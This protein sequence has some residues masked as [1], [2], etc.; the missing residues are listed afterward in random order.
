MEPLAGPPSKKLTS[1][2]AAAVAAEGNVLLIAGAGTGKTSTLV[3]RVLERVL[4]PTRRVSLDRI[5]MVTFTE[6]AAAEMRHRLRGELERRQLD[7]GGDPWIAEQIVRIDH[8]PI[9]TIHGFCLR[10]LRDHFHELGLDPQMRVL[11]DVESRSVFEQVLDEVLDPLLAQ[12]PEEKADERSGVADWIS[13]FHGGNLTL[14]KSLVKRVYDYGRSRHD[15]DT[16][17]HCQ[18]E[19]WSAT[20][21]QGWVAEMPEELNR[22]GQQWLEALIAVPKENPK[23][24]RCH[25]LLQELM[26]Q[27]PR[28][29]WLHNVG[30][31]LTLLAE[32]DSESAWEAYPRRKATLRAPLIKLFDDVRFLKSLLVATPNPSGAAGTSSRTV[33]LYPFMEDWTTTRGSMGS[34]LDVVQRVVVALTRTKREQSTV[35][36]ADLEQFALRLLGDGNTPVAQACQKRFEYVLVDEAQD[37]N[38]AQNSILSSV[39]RTGTAANRFLVGDIKQSIYRF[40]L[41]DPRI[42]QAFAHAWSVGNSSAETADKQ[43]RSGRVLPLT[44]NFRSHEAIL[45]FVNSVFT[46]LFHESL[47]GV[48]YDQAAALHFG[49]PEKRRPMSLDGTPRVEVHLRLES[50]ATEEDEDAG[51]T[52]SPEDRT[53][54]EAGLVIARLLELYETKTLVWDG[55]AGA[56]RPMRW[57]DVVVLLR[58]PGPRGSAYARKFADAGIPMDAPPGSLLDQPELLDFLSLLEILDNP[59]QDIPLAT[60][61]R[62]P[63]AGIH[64]LNELAVI[65]MSARREPFWTALNRFY[66]FGVSR[67]RE[68]SPESCSQALPELSADATG[69][70]EEPVDG[71][72]DESFENASG[73][74]DGPGALDHPTTHPW[75]RRLWPR[76]EGFLKLY[77]QWRRL[78]QRGS[79]ASLIET[80]LDDTGYEASIELLE[81]SRQRLANLRSLL[82][83]ARRFDQSQRGGVQRFLS[84]LK[85]HREVETE[86]PSAVSNNAVRLMS[87]H[88]SK[89]L[90]FPITVVAGLG[91][92][93]NQSDLNADVMLDDQGRLCPVVCR[94]GGLRY[95]SWPLWR[96]ARIQL[97]QLLGEELRLLYVAF[98]R[99]SDRLILVGV[100]SEK[101]AANWSQ[102]PSPLP[103]S[104]LERAR[105]PLDWLGPV[106]CGLAG[107]SFGNVGELSSNSKLA[108]R[109]WPARLPTTSTGVPVPVRTSNVDVN[110]HAGVP[111]WRYPHEAATIE[112]AK[113]SVTALRRRADDS[114]EESATRFVGV[115]HRFR[116]LQEDDGSSRL[117][118]NA[119][120][121]GTFH[122]RFLEHVD[123]LKTNSREALEEELERLRGLHR[124]TEE[125]AQALDMAALEQFWLSPLG[126]DLRTHA[127]GVRRE[128]PF[129]LRL[130]LD[131]MIRLQLPHLL[132]LASEEFVVVQGVIDIA[133]F[134]PDGTLWIGDF[135]TD[136]ITPDTLS[137]KAKV[138][139]PQLALYALAMERIFRVRVSRCWLYFL[140]MGLAIDVPVA[141]GTES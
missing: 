95:R 109:I 100:S 11:D 129:T 32:E 35:D 42:F 12:P 92:R 55:N 94:P 20:E 18:I 140:N 141:V 65:R 78:A 6:A 49:A 124:F 127:S 135:K 85:A 101:A 138:Y 90:E 116:I 75:A 103:L 57:G 58:S 114:E 115:D 10:L 15:F 136:R 44:A 9:G 5:L 113:Q 123:L 133:V 60:V 34:V 41:A 40:R 27:L 97:R 125:E 36:F 61:L 52:D 131:D 62:S 120:E 66:E 13:T 108:W 43:I 30:I 1:E 14:A 121:R 50:T 107:S 23:A 98:T 67:F 117:E 74:L 54:V 38:P 73:V 128:I 48:V 45:E 83:L 68:S 132:G 77:K 37:L 96:A 56:L 51:E 102:Q 80:I 122:H 47:G 33:P 84:H 39:S 17:L 110:V 8:A 46:P 112:P 81:H 93:F 104:W 119:A 64:D 106:L 26:A 139:G 63:L 105:K 79:M 21:P 2:Q 25:E 111:L 89:G 4:D 70:T 126:M 59:L 82:D 22:W 28:P 76:V 134:R 69:L 31:R 24:S 53:E 71:Q 130:G 137:E 16:W 99:A 87:I 72:F 86:A 118:F 29:N 88:A 7:L 91:N 3:T 19:E